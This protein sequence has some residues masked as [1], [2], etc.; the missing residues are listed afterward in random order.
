MSAWNIAS[1]PLHALSHLQVERF[2]DICLIE[3]FLATLNSFKS[4]T[5]LKW[6]CKTRLI[7]FSIRKAGK[8]VDFLP[9]V[10]FVTSVTVKIDGQNF[11]TFGRETRQY[12]VGVCTT[13]YTVPKSDDVLCGRAPDLVRKSKNSCLSHVSPPCH[14]RDAWP[15]SCEFTIWNSTLL[16]FSSKFRDQVSS[17]VFLNDIITFLFDNYEFKLSILYDITIGTCEASWCWLTRAS[18]RVTA[19]AFFN[20]KYWFTLFFFKS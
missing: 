11:H 5:T 8:R 17:A 4:T 3:H 20:P 16:L 2:P 1:R 12:G 10:T 6:L 15:I 13:H 18:S 19:D 7:T 9:R 14:A